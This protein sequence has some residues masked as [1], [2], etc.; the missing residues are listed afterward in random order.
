[1]RLK[2]LNLPVNIVVDSLL[3]EKEVRSVRSCTL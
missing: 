2:L 3:W 1:M